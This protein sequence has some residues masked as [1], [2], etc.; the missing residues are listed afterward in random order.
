[1][2]IQPNAMRVLRHLGLGQ[3]AWVREQSRTLGELV[4]LPE[5]LRN[6]ALRQRGI[7]SF[8]DRYRPLTAAP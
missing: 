5:P 8:Q 7:A 2:A 3:M 4:R 6:R 1:L